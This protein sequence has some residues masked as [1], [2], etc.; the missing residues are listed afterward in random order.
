MRMTQVNPTTAP[1]GGQVHLGSPARHCPACGAPLAPPEQPRAA[2]LCTGCGRPHYR[3]PKVGVGAVVRDEQGRLLLV[4]RGV[5]PQKGL[6]AL[7]AGFVDADEHP[8]AA[9]AREVLE[10]TGLDVGAVL[11]VWDG[12]GG[13]SFF[14]AFDAVVSGGS[15]AAADD[16]EDARF[17]SL[18]DLPSL[19]FESTLEVVRRLRAC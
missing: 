19:A 9:V 14:L 6:W 17:F 7:P 5:P 2:P 4:L 15:L 10:E 16:V 13:A 12:G 8:R 11:D 3:D 1:Y 18:D